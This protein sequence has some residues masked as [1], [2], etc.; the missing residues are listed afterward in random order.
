MESWQQTDR[1]ICDSLVL[2]GPVGLLAEM[3]TSE[4]IELDHRNALHVGVRRDCSVLGI[5]A[6]PGA[7]VIQL[8][9]AATGFSSLARQWQVLQRHAQLSNQTLD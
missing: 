9:A 3:R 7:L 8:Y 6:M 1:L 2:T 4:L 5:A